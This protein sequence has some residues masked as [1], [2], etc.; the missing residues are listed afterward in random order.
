[1]PSQRQNEVRDWSNPAYGRLLGQTD[2][3]SLTRRL[4]GVNEYSVTKASPLVTYATKNI[5]A[6]DDWRLVANNSTAAVFFAS[7]LGEQAWPSGQIM[8]EDNDLVA[9]LLQPY[10]LV[11]K[12]PAGAVL[13]T[14]GFV[15]KSAVWWWTP[16]LTTIKGG[17]IFTMNNSTAVTV[18]ITNGE[19]TVL[20]K[21]WSSRYAKEISVGL[22]QT[23]WS[24]PTVSD[25]AGDWVWREVG[26][27][28]STAKKATLSINGQGEAGLAAL[29]VV[30]NDQL[31]S[32]KNKVA[33]AKQ[34]QTN[35]V[36]TWADPGVTKQ[37]PS[38]YVVSLNNKQ[39][40]TLV[41]RIGYDAGWRLYTS[42][43]TLKPVMVDG[44]AMAFILPALNE[45]ATLEFVPQRS[46]H[47]L[48]VVAWLMVGILLLLAFKPTPGQ[49]KKD[50]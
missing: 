46:Y 14:D 6:A 3:V 20:A 48:E 35:T 4:E 9:S 13:P 41:V 31:S 47:A 42:K 38:H 30:P 26:I 8:G 16:A 27:Y 21:Y 22:D 12:V 5:V 17:Y 36:A 7:D 25:T 29:L 15:R 39:P 18:P 10:N 33:A 23:K 40:A 24:W 37:N 50:H 19:Y 44:Y 1:M 43:G 45:Q 2:G 28:S 49:P 32:A 11:T 34:E